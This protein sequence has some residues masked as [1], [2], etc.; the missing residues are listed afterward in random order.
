MLR[1]DFDVVGPIIYATA[2]SI[3]LASIVQ[4]RPSDGCIAGKDA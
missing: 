2:L 3:A 4:P 1:F